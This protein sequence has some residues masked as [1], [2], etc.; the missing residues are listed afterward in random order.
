MYIFVIYDTN[1]RSNSKVG[2]WIMVYSRCGAIIIQMIIGIV[3][4][5]KFFEIDL[6]DY[7]KSFLYPLIATIAM[8]LISEVT[9]GI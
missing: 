2:F 8:I 6:Q 3:F 7:F 4:M 1:M 5:K 9:N